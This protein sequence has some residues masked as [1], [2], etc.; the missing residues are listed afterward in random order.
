M[1]S[2]TTE[3]FVN[4]FREDAKKVGI[5]LKIQLVDWAEWIKRMETFKFDITWASWSASVYKDPEG[6][7][8]SKEAERVQGNNI[9]GYKN[10]MVDQ[11]IETLKNMTDLNK[12]NNIIKK[13]DA[14]IYK[15][16]PYILLWNIDYTRIL[17]WNKFGVPE[18][19][20]SKY[21]NESAVTSYWWCDEDKD[22]E[23]SDVIKRNKP[24]PPEPKII[25][26]F[27]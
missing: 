13:I 15:D 4:I 18:S 2:K 19:V 1:R 5:D 12:R 25:N 21:G 8:S 23:L 26:K 3:K 14:I 27:K 20:L 16:F 22:E 24:L 10:K 17:Y 7:W 9:T 11:Y 6:M